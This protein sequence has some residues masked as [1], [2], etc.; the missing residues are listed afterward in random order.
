MKSYSIF[1]PINTQ[2]G[3]LYLAILSEYIN[4]T[5]ESRVFKIDKKLTKINAYFVRSELF[6]LT[7]QINDIFQKS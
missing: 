2:N 4:L 6:S 1:C 3:S 7:G 5:I